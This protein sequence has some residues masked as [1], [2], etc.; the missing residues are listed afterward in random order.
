MNEFSLL[1]ELIFKASDAFSFLEMTSGLAIIRLVDL[2]VL[3]PLLYNWFT[4]LAD[5]AL[6]V[7]A[8]LMLR[9]R[10]K[11]GVSLLGVGGGLD[12]LPYD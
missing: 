2:E 3:L 12:P 7:E 10:R 1:A 9:E 6:P 11:P 5:S 4:L 8:K